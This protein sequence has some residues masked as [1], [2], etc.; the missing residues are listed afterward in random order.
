MSA[1]IL[2]EL[3]SAYPTAERRGADDINP[4]ITSIVYDSR[5]VERGSL[6]FACPGVHTDGHRFIPQA[7]ASG[8]AAVV[9]EDNFESFASALDAG[10]EGGD[11]DAPVFIR[12]DNARYAMSAMAAEFYG[13][14]ADEL[15]VIGVTGTDGKSS[16]VSYLHQLIESLGIPCGYSSTV[17]MQTGNESE[18]NNL[19][20]STPESPEIHALLRK[21]LDSG[22]KVAIVESTS[23][24]LSERTARLRDLSYDGALFT[25]IT[26]EHL[27]FHGSFEQYLSDKANLFR[28]LRPGATD[29]VSA[30]IS[31]SG[32]KTRPDWQPG[33]APVAV[34][35]A[36][37]ASAGYLAEAALG[38]GAG[39]SHYLACRSV[40]PAEHGS[41]EAEFAARGADIRASA[42][43]SLADRNRFVLEIDDES[44]PVEMP[45]PG[46]FNTDNILACSGL[47]YR[48]FG[49]ELKDIAAGIA[50]IRGVRGRMLPLFHGQPFA[51]L[52]DY[53]HT[54]G[55]FRVVFPMFRKSC[56]GKLI[57]V[58][59]SAGERD[60]EKRPIQG[61]IAAEYA[62]ILVITDED[63][64]LEDSMAIINEIA[65]GAEKS[66]FPCEIHRI[67]DRREAIRQAMSLAGEG[68]LIVM[69]G[70]GH[71]GSIIMAHGKEPWDEEQVARE[72]LSDM[73][74]VRI[75]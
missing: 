75:N 66:G 67:S 63:P 71:E 20:Q 15:L 6:F 50:G 46:S 21:M 12:V 24:G 16:T 38:A 30:V 74:Y 54:P 44:I 72:I 19:R 36:G 65:R 55:S 26:H 43:E 14:P 62:D 25:N 48:L 23:H 68:D 8:A 47:L 69:L 2:S 31:A 5:E 34:I 29:K 45:V 28:K 42:C 11:S 10:A 41:P 60:V 59:G 18:D 17:S 27:E 70:K 3:I 33:Q 22:K 58:F 4:L 9:H 57:A 52:V 1:R 39:V 35:N 7:I 37:D 40:G 32:L 49:A 53:A 73:G 51:A 64:R 56:S 61:E 13:R